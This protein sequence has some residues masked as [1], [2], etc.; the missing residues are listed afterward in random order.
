MNC[1]I[2]IDI[3]TTSTKVM[4]FDFQGEPFAKVNYGY[5]ILN[6]KPN[7][8]EQSVDEILNAVLK[9]LKEV[10]T[11]CQNKSKSIAG[12]SLSCAMH[13]VIVIDRSGKPLT[14]CIIWADT[15][16]TEYAEILKGNEQGHDIYLHTGTPIH[17]MSPLCKIAWI[18]EHQKTIFHKAWKFISIKEYIIKE[19]YGEYLADYSI[20]SATG[21]FDL[22]NLSWYNKSLD[23]AGI[24]KSHLSE[25][26]PTSHK[27]GKMKTS[28]ANH[29][30]LNGNVPMIIGASDGCLANLGSNA[31]QPGIAALT[32]GTSGAIRIASGNPVTD[33]KERTFCYLLEEDCYIIGGA[34]N[35][36][37][38]VLNWFKE[39]FAS[40][41]NHSNDDNSK[42][43]NK[44]L[45]E[46]AATVNPGANSLIFLPYL[47][48]ERSPFWDANARGLFFNI[49]ITHQKAHFIRAVMEGILY[50]MYTVG[51]ALEE[52]TGKINIISA[53]GGFTASSFWVQML[54]DI[55]STKVQ[56]IQTSESSSM[57][58]AIMGMKSLGIIQDYTKLN[59]ILHVVREYQPDTNTHPIYLKN[60]E[61]FESLYHKLKDS[62]SKV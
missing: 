42:D 29:L 39:N 58:A 45:I 51:Q 61:V 37:G 12:I 40:T 17:P 24:K 48:G 21:L 49:D 53:N 44:Q 26:V 59:E 57:G 38:V 9:G 32:I 25:L 22:K 43:L 1:I 8:H 4:A 35:N 20:A 13:S 56:I 5:P 34:V 33:P 2:T 16:S 15:R 30:G 62:F 27:L 19:L 52:T 18:R 11:L 14:D 55:F 54:A 31:I 46:L 50:G 47:L 6:P 7:F 41:K 23:F 28:Y 60:I 3:G 10:V 36:G